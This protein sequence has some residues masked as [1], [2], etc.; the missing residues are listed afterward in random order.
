MFS[1]NS[2]NSVTK[3]KIKNE[4]CE[5]GTQ[6]LLCKTE[7]IPLDHRDTGNRAY[8]YTEPNS[9]F[10]DSSDSLN[11]LNSLNSM[12]VPLHLEKTP[13]LPTQCQIKATQCRI[14]PTQ[15]QIDIRKLGKIQNSSLFG[16]DRL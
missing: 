2:L 13:T 11:L 8:P 7:M 6:D 4:H 14:E 15:C 5:V 1:L 3:K 12:K 16:G 9:C 10:S